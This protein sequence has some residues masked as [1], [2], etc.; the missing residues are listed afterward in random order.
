MTTTVIIVADN[1]PRNTDPCVWPRAA[2]SLTVRVINCV[3]KTYSRLGGL[4]STH[5]TH[6]HTY[7]QTHVRKHASTHA[8]HEAPPMRIRPTFK[9]RARAVRRSQ[10]IYSPRGRDNSSFRALVHTKLGGGDVAGI[11][12]RAREDNTRTHLQHTHLLLHTRSRAGGRRAAI[13]YQ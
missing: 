11:G 1:G 10:P 7:T 12:P 5:H 8:R 4:R 3:R 2:A 9:T 13:A 6:T